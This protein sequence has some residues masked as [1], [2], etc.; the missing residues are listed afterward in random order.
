MRASQSGEAVWC[1]AQG[2]LVLRIVIIVVSPFMTIYLTVINF[3][4]GLK[5]LSLELT[6]VKLSKVIIVLFYN[7]SIYFICFKFNW[8]L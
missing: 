5:K 6:K 8:V 7:V 3:K 2:A 4:P 1:S